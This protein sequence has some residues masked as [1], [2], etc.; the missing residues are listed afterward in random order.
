MFLFPNSFVKYEQTLYIAFSMQNFSKT[1]PFLSTHILKI[2]AW[3]VVVPHP[4]PLPWLNSSYL[5][6]IR[7]CC[8]E[9]RFLC[10]LFRPCRLSLYVLVLAPS[11]KHP[12]VVTLTQNL[13]SA[14]SVT[15]SGL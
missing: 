4:H 3:A 5:T 9:D 15:F 8:C 6:L 1:S 10:L 2:I 11:S 13:G 14:C 12:F 7:S